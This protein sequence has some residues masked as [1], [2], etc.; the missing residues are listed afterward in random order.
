M[1]NAKNEKKHILHTTHFFLCLESCLATAYQTLVF[2]VFFQKYRQQQYFLPFNH[3]QLPKWSAKTHYLRFNVCDFCWPVIHPLKASIF[4]CQQAQDAQTMEHL[5]YLW[6]SFHC[7]RE[8][9]ETQKASKFNLM[10][11]LT[12]P[13]FAC[14]Q[15]TSGKTHPLASFCTNHVGG[16]G[17][18]CRLNSQ[19]RHRPHW[20]LLMPKS[21]SRPWKKRLGEQVQFQWSFV[22]FARASQKQLWWWRKHGGEEEEEAGEEGEEEEDDDDDDGDGDGDSDDDG[23]AVAAA[24]AHHPIPVQGPAFDP[25]THHHK[26]SSMQLAK[27]SGGV[28]SFTDLEPSH[29]QC[30]AYTRR[31]RSSANSL[32]KIPYRN[33]NT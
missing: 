4:S 32:V 11:F 28:L 16:F 3:L 17:T 27:L 29:L 7:D 1:S 19:T 10:M 15:Y 14:S 6:L 20:E 5:K 30:P 24:V 9:E 22:H 12:Y 25:P 2:A 18:R 26:G 23:A 33:K 31:R 21:F 13:T 8:R